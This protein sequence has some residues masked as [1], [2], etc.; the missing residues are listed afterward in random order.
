M[1][2]RPYYIVEHLTRGVLI[3]ID[4][5]R[6]LGAR[7]SLIAPRSHAWHFASDAR[8][9]HAIGHLPPVIAA[10]C[11]VMRSPANGS[12]KWETAVEAPNP[13]PTVITKRIPVTEP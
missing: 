11:M 3:E 5:Q 2:E 6:Q 9:T 8:A 13:T 4:L 1:G 7:F 10:Q 12:H